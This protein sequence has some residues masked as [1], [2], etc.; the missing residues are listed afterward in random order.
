MTTTIT[1]TRAGRVGRLILD[2]EKRL[3]AIGSP[4][5]DELVA[6]LRT[7]EQDG[8]TRAVVISGAGRA[9]SAGFDLNA[10]SERAARIFDRGKACGPRP[11][12]RSGPTP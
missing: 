4:T 7:F 5:L 1:S 10:I 6:A 11:A 12:R 3:N 9:F 8:V 2:G